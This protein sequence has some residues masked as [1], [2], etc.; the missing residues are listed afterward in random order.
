[1]ALHPVLLRLSDAEIAT[2]RAY[3]ERQFCTPTRAA[4]M[5]VVR[6]LQSWRIGSFAL[7]L[8]DSHASLNKALPAIAEQLRSGALSPE[9][10]ANLLDGANAVL[11]A[12]FAEM[13]DG[14]A[15]LVGNE[16][17]N[18]SRASIDWE[19][20]RTGTQ[21]VL[22]VQRQMEAREKQEA[23]IE[24]LMNAFDRESDE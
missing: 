18:K 11:R 16:P 5:A 15:H 21:T 7:S 14:R 6:L 3:A 8:E 19:S 17:D 22:D 2:L 4:T 1:M 23:A 10:A 13:L 20:G 24:A 9:K 12:D